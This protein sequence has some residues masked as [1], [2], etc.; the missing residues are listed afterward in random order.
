MATQTVKT[1]EVQVIF[2][3]RPDFFQWE[4]SA[5]ALQFYH[6]IGIPY[7]D[8]EIRERGVTTTK[9]AW[10]TTVSISE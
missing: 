8:L 1:T 3:G 9:T 10:R 4:S 6:S 7:S 5:E 2:R